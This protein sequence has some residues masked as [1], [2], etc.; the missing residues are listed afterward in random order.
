MGLVFAEMRAP[1]GQLGG[2]ALTAG[3]CRSRLQ[4]FFMELSVSTQ[5]PDARP[6]TASC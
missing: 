2:R 3:R 4:D 6:D 1:V 5:S